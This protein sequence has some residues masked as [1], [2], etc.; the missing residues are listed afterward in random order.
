MSAT[1]GL[2]VI[3]RSW[4]K[5]DGPAKTSGETRYADDLFLPRM[6]HGK[7]LRSHLP[8]ARITRLDVAR[9]RALPGVRAVITG[10]DLPVKFGIM[11]SSQD[12]EALCLDKVRYVG[13]PVAAVAAVDEE[14]AERACEAI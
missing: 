3:G 5:V 8:H 13:D 2:R 14:T 6:L 12:E 7:I 1:D 11:P 10:A 4:S 9:A